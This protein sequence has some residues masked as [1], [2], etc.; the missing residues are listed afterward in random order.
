MPRYLEYLLSS[1]M[2]WFVCG[3]D[4]VMDSKLR[5]GCHLTLMVENC[6]N[7]MLMSFG[8]FGSLSSHTGYN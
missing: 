2:L 6:F 1:I 7:F 3:S 4:W 5:V 8:I